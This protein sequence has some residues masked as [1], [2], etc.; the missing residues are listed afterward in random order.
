MSIS[1]SNRKSIVIVRVSVI[2]VVNNHLNSHSTLPLLL[3]NKRHSPLRPGSR[4]RGR[5]RGKKVR[6]EAGVVFLFR[7]YEVRDGR[8]GGEVQ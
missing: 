8:L 6:G 4:K 2:E 7:N 5:K 3:Q 1:I